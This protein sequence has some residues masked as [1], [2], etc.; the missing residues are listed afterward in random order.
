MCRTPPIWDSRVHKPSPLTLKRDESGKLLLTLQKPTEVSPPPGR[1]PG[2]P[3]LV[4]LL[5]VSSQSLGLCV[6]TS[7]SIPLDY[8]SSGTWLRPI[9]LF[10]SSTQHWAQGTD[11]CRK[12]ICR[13]ERILAALEELVIIIVNYQHYLRNEETVAQGSKGLAHDH[14]ACK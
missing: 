7:P 11:G 13:T 5:L 3:Q 9:C 4:L 10:L 6:L 14:A 1:L 12:N 2:T 8:R